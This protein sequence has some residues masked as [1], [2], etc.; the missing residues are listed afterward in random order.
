MALYR[1]KGL[2]YNC[3]EKWSSSHRCKGRVLLFIADPD[4]PD[5]ATLNNPSPALPPSPDDPC[6]LEPTPTNPHISLYALVGLPAT[7]TFRVYGYIKHACITI[8]ID[9]DSTHN[10]VQP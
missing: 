7:D 9:S 3:D 1:E 4:D 6:P 2:Y 8:L 10:F 5:C